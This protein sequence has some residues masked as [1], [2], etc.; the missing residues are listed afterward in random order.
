M[1]F[2]YIFSHSFFVQKKRVCYTLYLPLI[3]I[4]TIKL[5]S[6]IIDLSQV[7]KMIVT[8]VIEMKKNTQYEFIPHNY[9]IGYF[10]RIWKCFQIPTLTSFGTRISSLD[11]SSTFSSS[12]GTLYNKSLFRL[13]ITGIISLISLR[14]TH[15]KNI[16]G[17][18]NF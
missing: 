6:V 10:Q 9:L 18:V 17:R 11:F 12:F 15:T 3:S 2:C 13:I 14:S 7:L 16:E 5:S 8:N 1:L 4:H